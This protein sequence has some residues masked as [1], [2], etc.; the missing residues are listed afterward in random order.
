[1]TIA[2]AVSLG[3]HELNASIYISRYWSA[4]RDWVAQAS[5]E[6]SGELFEPRPA[7]QVVRKVVYSSHP[8]PATLCLGLQYRVLPGGGGPLVSVV[9]F[10]CA[11]V[12]LLVA[13][14]KSIR[15]GYGQP[16]VSHQL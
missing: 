13:S 9:S 7:V 15:K 8:H 5:L 1:V 10:G 11:H 16:H 3:I 6:D 12:P 14:Q 4:Q 2:A